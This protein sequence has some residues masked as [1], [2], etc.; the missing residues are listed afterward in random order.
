[1]L[2]VRDA[3]G[4]ID[5][6]TDEG[7]Y[8]AIWSGKAAA[9]HVASYVGGEA[10]DLSG[11]RNQVEVELVPEL[12]VSRR[13][14]DMFYLTPG[15]Y[16]WIERCTSLVWGLTKRVLRADQTFVNIMLNHR[17]TGTAVD[18]VSDLV[19]ITPVLQRRAGLRDPAPPQR[20]FV[21]EV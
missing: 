14:H 2:L 13:F 17:V 16:L 4:L 19:R 11:Y 18:F 5:P 21:R 7:I 8:A 6:I 1:M 12:K 10:A 15:L 3:A 9:K 20:F